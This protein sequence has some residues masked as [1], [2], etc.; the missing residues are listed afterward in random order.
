[1][2][3]KDYFP[4]I[5]NKYKISEEEVASYA[6]ID[7]LLVLSDKITAGRKVNFKGAL[8]LFKNWNYKR[9]DLTKDSDFSVFDTPLKTFS[10]KTISLISTYEHEIYSF[11]FKKEKTLSI[12]SNGYNGVKL[13][14]D[15]FV[16]NI[17]ITT[18]SC[19]IAIEELTGDDGI[20]TKEGIRIYTI[21]RTLADKFTSLIIHG[22]RNTR[23]KDMIDLKEL[24]KK[25]NNLLLTKLIERLFKPRGIT[26]EK[27]ISF[28]TNYT[29]FKVIK[30][31]GVK[32]I[33]AKIIKNIKI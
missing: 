2:D 13:F 22:R 9:Q 19:D 25:S 7:S 31:N 28:K 18:I 29:S 1:M 6:T 27:Y 33:V 8:N 14:F 30:D 26:T 23:H 20:E 10:K 32:S 12:K 16:E 3:N 17:K 21:E 24:Y 5:M 4:Y 15:V 11:A